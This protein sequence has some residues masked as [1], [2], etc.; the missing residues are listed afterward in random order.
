MI[1]VAAGVERFLLVVHQHLVSPVFAGAVAAA[2]G[3]GL[4]FAETL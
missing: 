4:S 1:V 2:V 3:R